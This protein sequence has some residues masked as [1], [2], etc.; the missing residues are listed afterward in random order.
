MERAERGRGVL[1]LWTGQRVRQVVQ[2]VRRRPTCARNF[3]TCRRKLSGKPSDAYGGNTTAGGALK[4]AGLGHW[5]S[6]NAG[7]TNESGFTALPG[8]ERALTPVDVQDLTLSAVFWAKPSYVPQANTTASTSVSPRLTATSAVPEFPSHS[9][10]RGHSVRCVRALPQ[11]GCT[12]ANFMEYDPAREL[13]T[14]D[15][16]PDA[17]Y[18][19]LH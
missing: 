8:G 9:V 3:G 16:R 18:L 11:L 2:R 13:V 19:G 15:R 10:R 6:P 4:E 7:A 12:N 17:C 14:T 1:H 5:Q